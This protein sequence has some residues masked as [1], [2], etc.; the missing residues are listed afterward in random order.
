M[1]SGTGTSKFLRKYE[2]IPRPLRGQFVFFIFAKITFSRRFTTLLLLVLLYLA[3]K[4]LTH[5]MHVTAK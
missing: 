1:L 2:V 5:S 4:Q 3:Q